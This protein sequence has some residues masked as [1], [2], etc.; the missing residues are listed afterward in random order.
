MPFADT[1]AFL[2]PFSL[3]SFR[4]PR[5]RF[6]A[7]L[8]ADT[9][10]SSPFPVLLSRESISV[11]SC[12]WFLLILSVKFYKRILKCYAYGNGTVSRNLLSNEI[13]EP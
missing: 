3:S 9:T 12:C 2:I 1:R 8:E 4:L 10:L 6:L 11:S 5:F 7:R 13:E